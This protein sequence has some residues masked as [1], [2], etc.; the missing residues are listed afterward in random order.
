VDVLH[1]VVAHEMKRADNKVAALL[2]ER[3]DVLV[4]AAHTRAELLQVLLAL[5]V[6]VN[7]ALGHDVEPPGQCREQ[8]AQKKD[9]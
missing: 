3:R 7:D 6:L 5:R 8:L 4:R 1:E 9:N 2:Q